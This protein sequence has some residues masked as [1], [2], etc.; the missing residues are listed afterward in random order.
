MS[1]IKMHA[2]SRYATIKRAASSLDWV[3]SW[4]TSNFTTGIIALKYVIVYEK[5]L[6]AHFAGR[7]LLPTGWTPAGSAFKQVQAAFRAGKAE[8]L[9]GSPPM[10][11][12]KEAKHTLVL[13]QARLEVAL[14]RLRDELSL[15][16]SIRD[17]RWLA[18]ASK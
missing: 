2:E 16:M 1:L 12:T 14:A 3:H 13:Q 11:Y 7:I 6:Y 9:F 5:V 4:C 8:A 10:G 15:P 18:Y 17:K